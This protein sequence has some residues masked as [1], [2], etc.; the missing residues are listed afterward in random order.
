MDF[1]AV[2]SIPIAAARSRIAAITEENVSR[3]DLGQPNPDWMGYS[4]VAFT[5][6]ASP[7]RRMTL[8]V[9]AGGRHEANIWLKCGGYKAPSDPS[10]VSYPLF[11]AALLAIR[12][13]WPLPWGCAQ[14]FNVDY[15]KVALIPGESLFPYSCFHIPWLAYLSAPLAAGLELPTDISTERTSD[16]G[17]LMIAAE[18][19]LDPANPEH[20]RRARILAETMIARTGPDGSYGKRP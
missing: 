3:N 14:L 2:S 12:A 13:F 6:N 15:D 7:A 5:G 16:G 10:I 19:R 18:E 20:L 17:L 11:N 8:R 1:P 9:T 4:A